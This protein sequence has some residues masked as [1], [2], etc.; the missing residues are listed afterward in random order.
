MTVFYHVIFH[1]FHF[2]GGE[3]LKIRKPCWRFSDQKQFRCNSPFRFS[4]MRK[5]LESLYVEHCFGLEW[6]RWWRWW[7]LTVNS[8]QQNVNAKPNDILRMHFSLFHLIQF[9][10]KMIRCK[11]LTC[12]RSSNNWNVWQRCCGGELLGCMRCG[13][14]HFDSHQ[15][16]FDLQLDNCHLSENRAFDRNTCRSQNRDQVQS[17]QMD[18]HHRFRCRINYFR[19]N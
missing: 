10:S 6:R 18:Q 13:T 5:F 2:W 3:T 8:S 14:C 12:Q 19:F 4:F 15:N 11:Q 16:V 7:W 1:L 17:F 9:S